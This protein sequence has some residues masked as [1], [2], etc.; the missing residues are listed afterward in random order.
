LA[1]RPRT[2]LEDKRPGIT[3]DDSTV[4]VAARFRL[5]ERL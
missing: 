5:V 4:V 2:I 1:S 3:L